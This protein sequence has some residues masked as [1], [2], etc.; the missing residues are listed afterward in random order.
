[1]TEGP[2]GVSYK[3]ISLGSNPPRPANF[4]GQMAFIYLIETDKYYKIGITSSIENRLKSYRGGSLLYLLDGDVY[5]EKICHRFFKHLLQ[6]GNEW[7]KKSDEII[8]FFEKVSDDVY[9]VMIDRLNK[10]AVNIGMR[11]CYTPFNENLKRVIKERSCTQQEIA[12][13]CGASKQSVSRWLINSSQPHDLNAIMKLCKAFD[14]DFTWI[15]T[16]EG[17]MYSIASE[18]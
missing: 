2:V 10:K 14:I 8:D 13:I 9:D 6:R 17:S 16:G 15:L 4:G 5:T 12:K 11:K 3:K 7:Y 1:M 18:Q